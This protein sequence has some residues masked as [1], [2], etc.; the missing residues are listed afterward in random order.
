MRPDHVCGENRSLWAEGIV[1]GCAYACTCV[2]VPVVHPSGC[3][4]DLLA[5]TLV[6]LLYPLYSFVLRI[7]VYFA[8][9]SHPELVHISSL[10]M[11]LQ[12]VDIMRVNVEKVLERDKK[13][14]ELDDRAGFF[15]L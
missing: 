2:H 12:V 3:I 8:S 7:Y 15:H 10:I 1:L 4:P 11:R 14:S 9:H 6:Y 13:L 5:L